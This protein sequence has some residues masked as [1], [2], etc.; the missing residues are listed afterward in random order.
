MHP[1][2][3]EG[4]FQQVVSVFRDHP[5]IRVSLT[6]IVVTYFQHLASPDFLFRTGQHNWWVNIGEGL[7]PVWLFAPLVLG[8]VTLWTRRGD[9]FYRLLGMA[10]LISPIPVSLTWDDYLPHTNRILHF[11]MLAVVIGAIAIT[12]WIEATK[13]ARGVLVFLV[14]VALGEGALS[15]RTYFVDYA[16][17]FEGSGGYDRGKTD[18][19][20]ILFALRRHGEEVFL[21]HSFFDFGSLGRAVAFAG[22]LDC[23]DVRTRSLDELGIHDVTWLTEDTKLDIR[24]LSRGLGAPM[25]GSLVIGA[26]TQASTPGLDVVASTAE[27]DGNVI[28]SIYRVH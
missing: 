23:D 17:A 8:A 26:G 25:S 12:G 3:L 2:A 11:A 4:R 19:L 28:W 1:G 6:H 18:A 16:P 9:P 15:L 5:S 14:C 22:D 21:P 20:R 13:P 7:L 24:A 27:P 10:W